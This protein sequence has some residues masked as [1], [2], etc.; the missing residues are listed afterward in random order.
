[1]SR[2]E[3]PWTLEQVIALNRWQQGREDPPVHL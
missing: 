2:V 3:A 1:M